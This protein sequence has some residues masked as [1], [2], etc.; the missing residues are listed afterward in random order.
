MNRR[1]ED[2]SLFLLL[3]DF[4]LPHEVLLLDCFEQDEVELFA[5]A[6]EVHVGAATQGAEVLVRAVHGSVHAPEAE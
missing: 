6:R 2:A 1:R 4:F 5:D 3:E